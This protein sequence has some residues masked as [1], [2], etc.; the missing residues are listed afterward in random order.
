MTSLYIDHIGIIVTDLDQAIAKLRPLFGDPT[1]RFRPKAGMDGRSSECRLAALGRRWNWPGVVHSFTS[2][3]KPMRRSRRIVVIACNSSSHNH[4]SWSIKIA[5]HAIFREILAPAI[6]AHS[7]KHEYEGNVV[8][9]CVPH[10][11]HASRNHS[12]RI[13]MRPIQRGF[14]LIELM[15]VVAIIGILAAVALPAYQDYTKRARLSEAILAASACRTPISEVYQTSSVASLP[16]AGDWG[17]ES[18]TASSRYVRSV[19]TDD[20]GGVIVTAQG[21]GD[22]TIDGKTVSLVPTAAGRAAITETAP[23]AEWVCGNS[24]ALNGGIAVT[25]I[26]IRFLPVSCHG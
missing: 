23:L 5:A 15:I 25:T 21:T 4:R 18:S 8:V 7:L 9:N 16:A 22:A 1:S 17:C 11:R 19:A 3:F 26:P 10:P 6:F 13:K 2:E 14:T 12:K 20:N 24:A